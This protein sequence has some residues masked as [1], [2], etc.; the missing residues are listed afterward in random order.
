MGTP[1]PSLE[2]LATGPQAL[3]QDLG[4]PGLASVGVSPSG[5]ADRRAFRLGA[6]LLAQDDTAAAIEVTLGGLE[7]RAHGMLTLALTGAPAPASLDGRGVGHLG[8]FTL[9]DGEALHLAVPPV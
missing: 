6:R 4:R 7:V 9:R 3:I 1:R 8:P 2:V 5:A